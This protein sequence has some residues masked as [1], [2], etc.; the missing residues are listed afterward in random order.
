MLI[1]INKPLPEGFLSPGRAAL[2]GLAIGVVVIGGFSTYHWLARLWPDSREAPLCYW[3]DRADYTPRSDP[4]PLRGAPSRNGLSIDQRRGETT[5]ERLA[6]AEDACTVRACGREAWNKY[7][8][9]VF[10][11]LSP[12][13]QHTRQLDMAYGQPGLRRALDV[14]N[15][16]LDTQ[17]EKGLRDRYRAGGFRFGDFSQNR[18]AIAIVVLKGAAALRPC[19]KDDIAS[20]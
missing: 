8:S 10:W 13:L 17:F 7:R 5:S 14:Y 9:A 19:R 2:M 3:A 16:P 4:I 20:R 1:D 6:E 12:R 11:Y 18:D 15:Q